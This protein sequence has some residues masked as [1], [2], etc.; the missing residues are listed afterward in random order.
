MKNLLAKMG[1]NVQTCLVVIFSVNRYVKTVVQGFGF[2]CARTKIR[3]IKNLQ[4]RSIETNL[5]RS[6]HVFIETTFQS[7]S[8]LSD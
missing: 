6:K 1:D 5:D 7:T 2:Q 3:L 4:F 8:L